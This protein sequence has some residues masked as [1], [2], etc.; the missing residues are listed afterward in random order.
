MADCKQAIVVESDLWYCELQF[1]INRESEKLSKTIQ[2]YLKVHNSFYICF[3]NIPV[4]SFNILKKALVIIVLATLVNIVLNNCFI[5]CLPKT[6]A[7]DIAMES[8]GY[9]LR[10]VSCCTKATTFNQNNMHITLGLAIA[11]ER[12]FIQALSIHDLSIHPFNAIN[13]S[14]QSSYTFL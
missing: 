7:A 2:V 12:S 13:L 10:F 1:S 14:L 3:P 4:Y 5:H 8:S 6:L 11:Q 9:N